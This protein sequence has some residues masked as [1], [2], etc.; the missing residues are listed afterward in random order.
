MKI[1]AYTLDVHAGHAPCWMQDPNI[2]SEVLTLANCK[3]LIRTAANEGEW[4]AGVTPTRMTL[5]L[6]YLM[7]VDQKMSR[8]EY[9]ERYRS[10]RFD[11][12]YKPQNGSWSQLENPWHND[13]ESFR[14]DLSSDFIIWSNRFHVFAQSYTGK[15]NEV[16]G[17]AL[18]PRYR[19]LAKGGMR[20]YGHF[21]ELPDDFLAW[22]Q[23]QP[24]MVLCDFKVIRDFGDGG[25]GCCDS[26][27]DVP[28]GG[29]GGCS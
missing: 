5:R 15:C 17:L 18:D 1:R 21:I 22:I 23:K 25:C 26:D 29:C 11:S 16:R 13:E 12:I 4:I 6:A 19:A 7:R 27:K 10:S 8:E 2:G 24:R 28:E 20:G 9:W 3:P 14:R